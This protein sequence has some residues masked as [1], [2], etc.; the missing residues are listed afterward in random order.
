MF[1]DHVASRFL[2]D[3]IEREICTL[4]ANFEYVVP[5]GA[6]QTTLMFINTEDF[7]YSVRILTPF[8]GTHPVK[9]SGMR[10]IISVKSGGPITIRTITVPPRVNINLF[11]LGAGVDASYTIIAGKGDMV[12]SRT[13]HDALDIYEVTSHTVIK[14]LTERRSDSELRWTFDQELRSLYAEQSSATVSRLS[15]L[16]ELAHAAG[17]PIP[18][19]LLYL[20][21]ESSSPYVALL[22]IRSMLSSG[23]PEAFAQL[24]RASNH[25]PRLSAKAPSISSIPDYDS[26]R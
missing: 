6:S 26:S 15:N 7:E 16:L 9:W 24:H 18:D 13:M 21:L 8:L 14:T 23:H 17:K 1:S 20:T 10:Q 2:N 19:D 3:F 4:T 12:A 25:H 11:E 22:A 5:M